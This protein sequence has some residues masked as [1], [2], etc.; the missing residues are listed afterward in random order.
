MP[1]IYN[2]NVNIFEKIKDKY[3]GQEIKKK[4]KINVF[5]EYLSYYEKFWMPYFNN[6]MLNYAYLQ[7]DQ[8]SNSYIENYN[9]R[10]KLKLSKYLY[11]KKHCHISWAL[12]IYF[13]K[14]EEEDYRLNNIDNDS[15]LINKVK[16]VKNF[17]KC[18]KIL[19]NEENSNETSKDNKN[20]IN[21][22][23]IPAGGIVFFYCMHMS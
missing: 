9:R 15:A 6:G 7:K 21:G 2:N 1:Y 19:N 14:N 22:V 4:Y 3:L 17:N 23:I 10:I 20:F 18:V 11:G 12:F 5:E 13:I 16:E 8:R